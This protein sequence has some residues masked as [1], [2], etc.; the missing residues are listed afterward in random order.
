MPFSIY[1]SQHFVKEYSSI[2]QIYFISRGACRKYQSLVLPP[3]APLHASY[4]PPLAI[5]FDFSYAFR[6]IFVSFCSR[7]IWNTA[8]ES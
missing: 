8:L 5:I 3:P 4:P 7:T 1:A 6:R 2:A